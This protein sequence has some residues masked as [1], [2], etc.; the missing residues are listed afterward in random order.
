VLPSFDSAGGRWPCHNLR[1]FT[2][3]GHFCCRCATVT[4]GGWSSI[5]SIF[6]RVTAAH[7]KGLLK[8]HMQH[9]MCKNTSNW[10]S[11]SGR[12]KSTSAKCQ[13]D[14]KIPYTP[15]KLFDSCLVS[16]L[17]WHICPGLHKTVHGSCNCCCVFGIYH[18]VPLCAALE[19]TLA[20]I[21]V[22]RSNR[23]SR[24]I[25]LLYRCPWSIMVHHPFIWI[26]HDFLKFSSMFQVNYRGLNKMIKMFQV[27][28]GER[29]PRCSKLRLLKEGSGSEPH[30]SNGPTN[31]PLLSASDRFV[32][33]DQTAVGPV[34]CAYFLFGWSMMNHSMTR[35]IEWKCQARFQKE[36]MKKL[37]RWGI[38]QSTALFSWWQL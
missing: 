25:A 33:R 5:A 29:V 10:Q 36:R 31:Q 23:E 4:W 1:C 16:M 27:H 19:C 3:R 26:S 8:I 14:K 12:S 9:A 32:S 18:D 35:G 21:S 15:S 34:G 22:G 17:V 28:P 11:C 37:Y 6:R 13:G 30:R 38:S 24:Q 7:R 20:I 2:Y